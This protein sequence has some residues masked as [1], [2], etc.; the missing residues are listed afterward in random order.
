[1]NFRFSAEKVQ[2]QSGDFLLISLVIL[3]GGIGLA[4]LFSSSY[5]YGELRFQDPLYFVKRQAGKVL[6]GAF[7][8]F[9]V[10]RINMAAVKKFVPALLLSAL[11]LCVLTFVPGIGREIMGA[12]R[13][14]FIG[15]Q[16]FQPSELAKLAVILYLAYIFSKK[17]DRLNDFVRSVFPPLLII[18]LFIALIYLQNDFSTALF[19]FVLSLIIFF[20]ARIKVIYF[21][22]LGAVGVPLSVVLIFTKEHR[23]LRI[24]S[25]LNP[26]LDPVGAGYQIKAAQEAL[27]RGGLWGV[28]LGEG[29][30]KL[31]GLPE[32]HSD[33]VFAVLGEEM[34]FIGILFILSLFIAFAFRGYQIAVKSSD[35]FGYYC[36]F[37]ITTCILFQAL[38]NIAVVS[39]LVPTTGIPLPF[40]SS[41][42]SSILMTL[43][44]CGFLVNLSRQNIKEGNR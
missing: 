22:L 15:P 39:G 21:L 44:M 20:I 27:A 38:L 40:F 13:W 32:A 6:F 42:G 29:T 41:G 25:F 7:L 11:L 4:M 35:S 28:G 8:A 43:V 36:A 23:V 31:G 26:E 1:M 24:L 34:G 18:F 33:F 2:K 16:S 17:E 19:I 5:Y 9:G 37:G 10:S 3:L 12:R 30:K 14:I